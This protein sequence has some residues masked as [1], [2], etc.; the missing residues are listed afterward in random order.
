MLQ[1]N[2]M[3][4]TI[5]NELNAVKLFAVNHND[6]R[7]PLVFKTADG[8]RAFHIVWENIPDYGSYKLMA[9][10]TAGEIDF[11][12][13]NHTSIK[14]GKTSG[15][16]G[17][18]QTSDNTFFIKNLRTGMDKQTRDIVVLGMQIKNE[19]VSVK[20]P[21]D[22]VLK[23]P[24]L[25]IR[26]QVEGSTYQ[27]IPSKF[28]KATIIFDLHSFEG[29]INDKF[30]VFIKNKGI[31]YRLYN[32]RASRANSFV[33]RQNQST[34]S[35]LY[36][37]INKR[38]SIRIGVPRVDVS[39]YETFLSPKINTEENATLKIQLSEQLVSRARDVVYID[40]QGFLE[41]LNSFP[42]YQ[43]KN[44]VLIIDLKEMPVAGKMLVL[45]KTDTNYVV[46]LNHSDN[47]IFGQWQI[48]TGQA[49]ELII[50]P[51]SNGLVRPKRRQLLVR[52]VTVND[53]DITLDIPDIEIDDV[54]LTNE[55][56]N[57]VS[58]IDYT[59]QLGKLTLHANSFASIEG[60]SYKLF[61]LSE[62]IRYR[63]F[64]PKSVLASE[65]S[66][67]FQVDDKKYFYFSP[68]GYLKYTYLTLTQESRLF[69]NREFFV[70]SVHISGD[71]I[72]ISF[73]HHLDLLN[74]DAIVARRYNEL[75]L[76]DH[77]MDNNILTL[78]LNSKADNMAKGFSYPL[79]VMH[80]IGKDVSYTTI[81]LKT[82]VLNDK[83]SKTIHM[84]KLDLTGGSPIELL[85]WKSLA[86]FGVIQD[87]LVLVKAKDS[88]IKIEKVMG[89]YKERPVYRDLTEGVKLDT[90]K[91][92]YRQLRLVYRVNNKIYATNVSITSVVNE[93]F[94]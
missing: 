58:F 7:Y 33:F 42:K 77:T 47:V 63:L 65:F 13:E 39:S 48:L 32:Y 11:S 30:Y 19:I 94:I 24:T 3:V 79:E 86:V 72:K 68:F 18:A 35:E 17:W 12:V 78:Q 81:I 82:L 5:D 15:P 40:N 6:E 31:K 55:T 52:N 66:R 50:T 26:N 43:V 44:N 1:Q 49:K 67:Y 60:M 87:G 23:N 53:G 41:S 85:S 88:T 62:G 74:N 56:E 92:T 27:T 57:K 54:I 70:N 25:L 76:F 83:K 46:I 80:R 9:Q 75:I 91:N 51:K 8:Q 84:Q 20:L 90:L 69:S 34:I 93:L 4:V 59:E 14:F 16:Y 28:D 71:S 21:E 37:T 89:E 36:Y 10:T 29:E 38:L 2:K 22:I 61:I 64:Y 45:I 73:V